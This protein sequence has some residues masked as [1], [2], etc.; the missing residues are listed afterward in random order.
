MI[1]KLVKP[2]IKDGI[3]YD[4]VYLIQ[5]IISTDIKTGEHSMYTEF[6][7]CRNVETST[8][9]SR[10]DICSSLEGKDIMSINDLAKEDMTKIQDSLI[11]T[12]ATV[13]QQAGIFK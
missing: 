8:T 4:S 5:L 13:G 12:L 1:F 2:I 11:N 6:F 7:P 10:L 9:E 3:T